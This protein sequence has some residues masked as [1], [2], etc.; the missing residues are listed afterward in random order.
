MSKWSVYLGYH[1]Y[2]LNSLLNSNLQQF[3]I[4]K[5]VACADPFLTTFC[6]PQLTFLLMQL[7]PPLQCRFVAQYSCII[8]KF[9]HDPFYKYKTI[10]DVPT[11][12]FNC[13]AD[14]WS[15][16]ASAGK[17]DHDVMNLK[18]QRELGNSCQQ[19]RNRARKAW[20]A[21]HSLWIANLGRWECRSQSKVGAHPDVSQGLFNVFALTQS[22]N[23]M[24][25]GRRVQFVITTNLEII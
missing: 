19:P 14:N 8:S 13:G 23:V 2:L 16:S 20:T 22:C 21:R 18:L 3:L 15:C 25:M 5:A 1:I 4:K 24:G 9:S 10:K 11:L 6:I 17:I 12:V 7:M